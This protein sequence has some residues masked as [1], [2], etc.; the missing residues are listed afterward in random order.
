[1]ASIRNWQCIASSLCCKRIIIP[2]ISYAYNYHYYYC[3]YYHL[4]LLLF[5]AFFGRTSGAVVISSSRSH[6]HFSFHCHA[7]N[8]F[9]PFLLTAIRTILTQ[10]WLLLLFLLRF[11]PVVL[12]LHTILL[13]SAK[14]FYLW[15]AVLLIVCIPRLPATWLRLIGRRGGTWLPIVYPFDCSHK[16]AGMSHTFGWLNPLNSTIEQITMGK[17]AQQQIASM[18][19]SFVCT[20]CHVFGIIICVRC[21]RQQQQ[22][23]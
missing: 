1:M 17:M 22:Q 5:S 6:Y 21:S 3:Y 15:L 11:L 4:N 7:N 12:W 23:Q 9:Q 14:L 13:L 20:K 10:L 2:F 8:I 19:P 16:C 18:K